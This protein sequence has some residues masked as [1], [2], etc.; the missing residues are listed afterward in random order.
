[1]MDAFGRCDILVNSAGINIPKRSWSQ[2][3]PEGFDSVIAADLNGPFYATHAVL[4]IMR[5][6]KSGLIIQVSS[7][8]GVYVSLLTGPAY[9]AAK[10]GLVAMSESINQAECVN[11][12]RSCC[13]C[14]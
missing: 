7:W 14:P 4:P 13:I 2:V 11:G 6:Q 9:S 3:E 1:M 10:H 5:A 12:I 8:A